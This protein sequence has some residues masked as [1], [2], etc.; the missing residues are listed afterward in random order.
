MTVSVLAAVLLHR[1]PGRYSVRDR[2][3]IITGGSTGLGLALAR[4]VARHGAQLALLARDG[5][6]AQAA[7][8]RRCDFG[9]QATIWPCDVQEAQDAERTISS[10]AERYGRTDVLVNNAGIMLVAPLEV[11]AKEDFRIAS[12]SSCLALKRL[13]WRRQFVTFK[14]L[15]LRRSSL[16]S[17]A[18]FCAGG[19]RDRGTFAFHITW[20]AP[21][22]RSARG[23]FR[24]PKIG[25]S[26]Y[27][28]EAGARRTRFLPCRSSR[29]PR[30]HAPEQF[31]AR[32][33]ARDPG[34]YCS[35][36]VAHGLA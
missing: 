9:A 26:R 27:C 21:G 36:P 31:R 10:I 28:G 20:I 13:L 2:V 18:E 19:N 5:G 25:V 7:S 8:C 23:L 14:F 3:V 29:R 11:M 34:R 30:P 16:P 32:Y 4:E 1:G 22:P 6:G 35:C 17:R 24:V 15:D 12:L 33:T